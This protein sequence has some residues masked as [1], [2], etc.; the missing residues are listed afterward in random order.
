MGLFTSN[1]ERRYKAAV[2][3]Y[4]A[5]YNYTMMGPP[6]RA[7]VDTKAYADMKGG[8]I[9]GFSPIEF[10]KMWPSPMRA[11]WRAYAMLDLG[12][13]PAVEGEIWTLPKSRRVLPGFIKNGPGKLFMAYRASDEATSRAKSYLEAKG[14]DARTLEDG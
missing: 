8:Y 7:R 2:A 4:L 1:R 5:A 14:V 3:I 12:I 13:P 9:G 11:A 10:Q 6:E